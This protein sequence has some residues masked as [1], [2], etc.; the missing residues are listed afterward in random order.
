MGSSDQVVGTV[1]AGMANGHKVVVY[2][3]VNDK[4]WGPKPGYLNPFTSIDSTGRWRCTIFTGDDDPTATEIAAYLVPAGLDRVPEA[5]G[6]DLLPYEMG[7]Y[8]L[9]TVQRG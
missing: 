2:I 4:W 8:P 6:T 3:K 9:A 1:D 5:R 7:T